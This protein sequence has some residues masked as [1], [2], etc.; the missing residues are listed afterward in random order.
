MSTTRVALFVPCYNVSHSIEKVLADTKKYEHLFQ[1]IYLIDNS[2]TDNTPIKIKTFLKNQDSRKW[3]LFLNEQNYTLGG[4]TIIAFREA[5]QNDMDFV[6]CMHSDGQANVKDLE[7]FF[8]L[9]CNEDFVCGSRLL[10]SSDVK[11]YSYMRLAANRI[12]VFLQNLILRS[13]IRDIG[14]FLAFNL[15]TVQK[16]PYERIEANMAYH[17]SLV[18]YASTKIK[19][20][21]M[22]EFPI[23]WGKVETSN[24]NVIAYGISH[25]YRL[26]CF[27]MNRY[28]LTD[29]KLVDFRTHEV[30]PPNFE[31]GTRSY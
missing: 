31:R 30:V 23:S 13:D 14:A 22:R 6:I 24:V 17:P 8:P 21:K 11:H 20:L 15:H 19:G 28:Q 12:F 26:L 3:H 25:L 4:S 9:Q 16:I 18:L 5:I 29:Q 10:A 1:A 7:K 2:S 27:Y